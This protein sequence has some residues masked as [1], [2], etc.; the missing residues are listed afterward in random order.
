MGKCE[1]V[2]SEGFFRARGEPAKLRE[3]DPR[4]QGAFTRGSIEAAESHGK[5]GKDKHRITPEAE[6]ARLAIKE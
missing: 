6:A 4:S 1:T 2:A 3:R 5:D